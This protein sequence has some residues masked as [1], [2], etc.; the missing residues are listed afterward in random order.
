M[1]PPTITNCECA[2]PGFCQRHQCLKGYWQHRLCRRQ[3]SVFLAYEH[4]EGPGQETSPDTD[5]SRD[6]SSPGPAGPGLLRRGLNFAVAGTR[7]VAN[8]MQSVSDK[9]YET[10][11]EECRNCEFCDQQHMVCLKPE[12]GCF[13]KVKARWASESCPLGKWHSQTKSTTDLT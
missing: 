11:L 10:R 2:E 4:G 5:P 8:G 6:D 9:V 1:W 3:E 13:V 7:H 12:C